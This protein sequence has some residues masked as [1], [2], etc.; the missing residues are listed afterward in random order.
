MKPVKPGLLDKHPA[1]VIFKPMPIYEYICQK[2]GAD[3]EVIQKFSDPPLK[4]HDG[5]GGKLEKQLSRS[6]FHL[7]GSGWY[8]DG[9][10]AKKSTKSAPDKAKTT[11]TEKKPSKKDDKKSKPKPSKA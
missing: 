7:K 3:I 1:N 9:Y 11:T 5:C 2:C 10:S 6:A 8:A 4:R